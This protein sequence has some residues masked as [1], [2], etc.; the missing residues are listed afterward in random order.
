MA[1]I[2]IIS[3]AYKLSFNIFNS[4]LMISFFVYYIV[5]PIK[6]HNITVENPI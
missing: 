2:F 1:K 3:Y 6:M 4:D 5:N